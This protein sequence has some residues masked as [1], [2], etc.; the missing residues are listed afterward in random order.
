MSTKPHFPIFLVIFSILNGG[1]QGSTINY[2]IHTLQKGLNN[3]EKWCTLWRV[4]INTDKIHAV[5]FLK[6]TSRKE[7]KSLSFFDE[8]L[9]W[10]QVPWANPT[11][12]AHLQKPS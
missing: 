10:D 9:T 4:A 8:D 3:I 5:M 12:Q 6:G 11:R 2:V 1:A 7:L